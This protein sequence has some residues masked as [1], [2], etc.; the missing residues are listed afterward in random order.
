MCVAL[1]MYSLFLFHIWSSLWRLVIYL[2]QIDLLLF[3]MVTIIY[4]QVQANRKNR[5]QIRRYWYPTKVIYF[6]VRALS[7]TYV[8]HIYHHNWSIFSLD[9][10]LFWVEIKR[11]ANELLHV[12]NLL[13]WRIY[14]VDS[15]GIKSIYHVLT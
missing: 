15:H 9:Q 5:A 11:Q 13:K 8:Q 12:L 7:F 3:V 14:K 6:T 4:I 2:L 10:M 1:F